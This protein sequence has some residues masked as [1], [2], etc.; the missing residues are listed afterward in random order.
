MNGDPVHRS[1]RLTEPKV[2]S[3]LEALKII[4]RGR[5]YG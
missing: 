5:I 3:A 2:F 4:L 1:M